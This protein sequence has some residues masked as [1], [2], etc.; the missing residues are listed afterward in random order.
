MSQRILKRHHVRLPDGADFFLNDLDKALRFC[1][2]ENGT[3]EGFVEVPR[4]SMPEA[5]KHMFA[6]A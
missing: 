3:Y 1:D 2:R 4:D 5:I 6:N